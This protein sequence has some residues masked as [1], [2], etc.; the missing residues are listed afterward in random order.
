M[1]R[2]IYFFNIKNLEEVEKGEQNAFLEQKGPYVFR[3]ILEKNNIRF[4]ENG[5]TLT[6]NPVLNFQFMPNMS[7]GS[8]N[9]QIT[10]LNIPAFVN[11]YFNVLI[12]LK[13]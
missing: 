11:K 2:K 9:D 12:L 3:E 8:L 10:T 13:I 6:Y 5:T 4:D 1:Y 7:V